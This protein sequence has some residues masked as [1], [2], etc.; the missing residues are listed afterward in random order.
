M[1]DAERSFRHVLDRE[2][3]EILQQLEDWLEIPMLVLGFVWLALF[4]IELVWGLPP[5]L[6]LV[7]LAIWGVFVFDFA[8]EFLLSPRKGAYLQRNWLTAFALLLP[9][10]RI[11]RGVKVVRA[12]QTTRAVRGIRLLRAVTRTNRGMRALAA[13][14]KRRGFGYLVGL[15]GIVTLAGSAGIYAFERD[16]A[17]S[18]LSD[19]G[20]ALWWTAMVMTTMG[21]DYFPK[22][23]EGRVLC[24][25]LA[26]YAFAIF[27]YVTATIATFFVGRD[28]EDPKAE[29]AGARALAD[30]QAEIAALRQEIQVLIR[31]RDGE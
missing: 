13:S 10:L 21:S 14:V 31:Q 12:L 19:Y 7:S 30:L 18:P 1:N 26:L 11:F 16:L 24:F 3:D 29:V 27:G 20:A 4:A 6:D 5:L 28:A 22:T 17:G 15:T 23:A 8:L 25:L 9:A 2:R